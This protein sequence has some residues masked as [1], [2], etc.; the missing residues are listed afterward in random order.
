MYI[1]IEKY[2]HLPLLIS[3]LDNPI[4]LEKCGC[5]AAGSRH[6]VARV[7]AVAM[8]HCL[9][10]IDLCLS[11]GDARFIMSFRLQV[12]YHMH[13]VYFLEWMIC[14]NIYYTF[15]AIDNNWIKWYWNSEAC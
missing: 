7:A 13:S 11:L 3:K 8:V 1:Y 2:C 6:V 15:I 10:S 4:K 5:L 14:M 12:L 9:T